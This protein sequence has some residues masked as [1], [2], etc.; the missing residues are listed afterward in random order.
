MNAK[1]ALTIEHCIEVL[2][3]EML[4][5]SDK[6][7]ERKPSERKRKRFTYN[8]AEGLY[9]IW[10]GRSVYDQDM[11]PDRLLEFYNEL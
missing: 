7:S 11:K 4:I 8:P 1:I 9:T 2:D 10:V 6:T 3:V 5:G